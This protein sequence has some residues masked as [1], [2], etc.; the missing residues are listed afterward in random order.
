MWAILVYVLPLAIVVTANLGV[1]RR[2][3]RLLTYILLGLLHAATLFSGVAFLVMAYPISIQSEPLPWILQG[4]SPGGLGLTFAVT[5]VLGFAVLV[6]SVRRFV[7]RRLP[8]DP[9]SPVHTTALSM[10]VYLAIPSAGLLLTNQALVRL[11]T[12]IGSVAPETLTLGQ[13][14]FLGFAVCGVG[15]GTRR[16]GRQTLA[17]LGLSALKPRHLALTAA[18]VAAFLALDYATAWLWHQLWPT[19]YRQVSDMTQ[20]LFARFTSPSGALIMALSAGIGEELLFRG[21]L[22][23]RFGIL[24][25]SAVFALGHVQYALSPAI[26]EVFIVGL[27]LGRLRQKSNTTTCIAAHAGYNFVNVLLLPFL[28]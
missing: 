3:W 16:N 12:E 23:P 11:S 9:I 25:T 17:R 8:I 6:P 7:A 4:L 14:L 24:L 18:I 19:S 13:L 21:A 10:L 22:Q 20:Q 2:F 5:A 27:V 28:P 1:S 26:I 15:L